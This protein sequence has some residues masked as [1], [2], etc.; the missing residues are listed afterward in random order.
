MNGFTKKHCNSHKIWNLNF[1]IYCIAW[2]IKYFFILFFVL[3]ILLVGRE[4]RD[5]S[6]GDIYW[7]TIMYQILSQPVAYNHNFLKEIPKLVLKNWKVI[8]T[9][10]IFFMTSQESKLQT[11]HRQILRKESQWAS[12]KKNL[13]ESDSCSFLPSTVQHTRYSFGSQCPHTQKKL[14]KMAASRE[15]KIE[16]RSTSF[17]LYIPFCIF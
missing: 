17:S 5:K 6:K 3:Y 16:D 15:G 14:V 12:G 2:F 13:S 10:D 8:K 1:G 4:R 9:Q 11:L 7:S